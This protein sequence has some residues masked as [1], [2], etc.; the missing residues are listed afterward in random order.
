MNID[1]IVPSN[2]DTKTKENTGREFTYVK[3]RSALHD[4]SFIMVH[5]LLFV[6][7]NTLI[8]NT[9]P[10]TD[11][12]DSLKKH[13]IRYFIFLVIYLFIFGIY[14]ALMAM[15][16]KSTF[17]ILN[18]LIF[19]LAGT[20][21]LTLRHK[22]PLIFTSFYAAYA[23][24]MF[25]VSLFMD[26][27]SKLVL[28]QASIRVLPQKLH[29]ILPFVFPLIMIQIAQLCLIYIGI[30]NTVG[31][32]FLLVVISILAGKYSLWSI[33]A[34]VYAIRVYVTSVIILS[35]DGRN[36]A[37]G[38]FY[39]ALKNTLLC[40]GSILEAAIM[41]P[42]MRGAIQNRETRYNTNFRVVIGGEYEFSNIASALISKHFGYIADCYNELCLTFMACT[43]KNYARSM[44]GS[45]QHAQRKYV[46]ILH[47]ADLFFILRALPLF[48]ISAFTIFV[49]FVLY[50]KMAIFKYMENLI[51]PSYDL[52]YVF[53]MD[54]CLKGALT[55]IIGN[56]FNELI[57]STAFS[58][59]FLFID[60]HQRMSMEVPELENIIVPVD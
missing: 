20:S 52:R 7:L 31:N 43:G 9:C 56:Y 60:D 21:F 30:V 39:E 49:Y 59:M 40:S 57:S 55:Y 23:A 17:Y 27:N 5:S 19:A 50:Y 28:I 8:F 18:G 24:I 45:Y 34:T 14:I 41:N 2:D 36:S 22:E 4:S 32:T 26:L 12:Y 44:Q 53:I 1:H 48:V 6:T 58:L 3:G 46:N 16:P 33:G 11:L 51:F 25:V 29:L 54:I 47:L 13:F 35:R 42:I 15:F 37:I 10:F 38:I